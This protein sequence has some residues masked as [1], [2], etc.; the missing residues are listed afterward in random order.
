MISKKVGY[1]IDMISKWYPKNGYF[2][3]IIQKNIDIFWILIFYFDLSPRRS[4]ISR[5][6]QALKFST[7]QEK[8][9]I[10]LEKMVPDIHI[11]PKRLTASFN[12]MAAKN[13]LACSSRPVIIVIGLSR[14]ELHQRPGLI[15]TDHSYD[16]S[17]NPSSASTVWGKFPKSF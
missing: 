17:K 11:C 12:T 7:D 15:Q 2:F 5:L 13:R 14:A 1:H 9:L 3:D 16:Q 6:R 10:S 8:Y 4:S